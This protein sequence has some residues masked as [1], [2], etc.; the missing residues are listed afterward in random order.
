MITKSRSASIHNQPYL[1]TSWSPYWAT[2]RYQQGTET[3][4]YGDG[5]KY[6]DSKLNWKVCSHVK[7]GVYRFGG[8]TASVEVNIYGSIYAAQYR[9]L[10]PTWSPPAHYTLSLPDAK[11]CMEKFY[12]QIDLNCHDSVLLYSGILQAIP[13]LGGALRFVSVMN[14]LS[15]K[16]SRD[17]RRKPFT[18]VIKTAI[19]LDFID[20]FVVGPTIDDARKFIDATNYVLRVMDTAYQRS[21]PM[22]MAYEHSVSNN[23]VILDQSITSLISASGPTSEVRFSGHC[24]RSELARTTSHLLASVAYDTS[25]IDP[26]KL[27]ATRM[28]INRPL[29]SAWDLVPFS[30]VVDYFARAGEF[31]SEIGDK[32]TDQDALRGSVQSFHGA[33]LTTTQEYTQKVDWTNASNPHRPIKYFQPGSDSFTV[34]TFSRVPFNPWAINVGASSD[35]FFNFD[36]SSTRKRTLAQLFIQAKLR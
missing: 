1:W 14:K 29:D 30:F 9:P 34:S 7:N 12:E 4:T 22:P 13:L 15:R 31:I 18:T 36:L 23:R 2:Q 8:T 10:Q 35:G 3:L 27:A 6:V 26:I 25:A 5:P 32:F 33:W 17:L 28:G 19:S 24:T 21:Q 11:S 16:L 20:R